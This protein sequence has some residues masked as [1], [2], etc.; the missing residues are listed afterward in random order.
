[1]SG[2]RRRDGE[3]SLVEWGGWQGIEGERAEAHPTEQSKQLSEKG[4]YM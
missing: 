2:V 4:K 3:A 1:M